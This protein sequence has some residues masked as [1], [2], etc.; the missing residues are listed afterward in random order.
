MASWPFIQWGIDIVGPL[1]EAP[2]KVKFLI[3]AVDY[4][5]KWV[6][7]NPIAN[8]TGKHVE[9]FMLEHIDL[10][11]HLPQSLFDVGSRRISI[12][13]MNTFRHHSDVLA[14]SQG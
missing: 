6:E 4:F 10:T 3:I 1:P 5:T 9:I 8:V 14:K 13:T 2:G 7:A 12:E 11:N